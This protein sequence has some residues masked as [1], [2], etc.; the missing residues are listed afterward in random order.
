MK[1]LIVLLVAMF[2]ITTQARI[3]E[4]IEQLKARYGTPTSEL[5]KNHSGDGGVIKLQFNKNGIKIFAAVYFD[6]KCHSILYVAKNNW[7]PDEIKKIIKVNYPKCKNQDALLKKNKYFLDEKNDMLFHW[8]GQD[9]SFKNQQAIKDC[10]ALQSKTIKI[11]IDGFV[12]IGKT[13]EELVKFYGLPTNTGHLKTSRK[14]YQFEKNGVRVKAYIFND[15]KCYNISFSNRKK[16]WNNE[17]FVKFF[18]ANYPGKEKLIVMDTRYKRKYVRKEGIKASFYHREVKMESRE[19]IMKIYKK[20]R[21]D[22]EKKK[23]NTDGF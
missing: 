21:E 11:N 10:I 3:G 17:D 12:G 13:I 6:K 8:N 23:N 16:D 19:T 4:T 15:G 20:A 2:A 9:I 1:K 22:H 5:K 18:K 14:S 7:K